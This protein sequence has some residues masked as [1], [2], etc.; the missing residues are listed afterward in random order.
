MWVSPTVSIIALQ[1]LGL[2][3]PGSG[4]PVAPLVLLLRRF[5]TKDIPRHK[6]L[7]VELG[8]NLKGKCGGERFMLFGAGWPGEADRR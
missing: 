2:A 6:E 4:R 7:L 3:A 5:P 1:L 8:V